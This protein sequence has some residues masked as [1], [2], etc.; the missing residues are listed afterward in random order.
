MNANSW[1]TRGVKTPPT[2]DRFHL[3]LGCIAALFLTPVRTCGAEE[4]WVSLSPSLTELICDLGYRS[5]LVGRS[6]ACDYPPDV[7]LVPVV[8]DFGRP[9]GELLLRIRPDRVFAT[10]LERPAMLKMLKTSGIHVEWLPCETWEQLLDA[11][12]RI[13]EVAGDPARG[14]D[15]CAAMAAKRQALAER[16]QALNPD[17][18]KPRVYIEIWHHP[19]TTA[20]G[21]SFLNELVTLAGSE[22]IAANLPERYP[23]VNSEWVVR[24][25]PDAI[26][27]AYMLPLE[28]AS[29]ML[30]RRIGWDQIEAVRKGAICADIPPD[31][32]LRPG[33]R[34]LEGAERLATWL[35]RHKTPNGT[36][37]QP[38]MEQ[39]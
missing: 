13:C 34:C 31:L 27:L 19:L 25:N 20:G 36:T 3:L 5:N 15:W 4:R 32:L 1:V 18:A 37:A 39:K 24:Q 38:A 22:N 7:E 28:G 17:H 11:A 26:V 33:P 23:H 35:A 16:V 8:G 29:A 14:H 2:F 21:K 10:D 9:N 12:R 30:G 6:S